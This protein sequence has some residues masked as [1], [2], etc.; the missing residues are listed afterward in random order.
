MFC[1]SGCD[2]LIKETTKETAL[3]A[4]E[5]ALSAETLGQAR[6]KLEDFYLS[7]QEASD[8]SMDEAL[9]LV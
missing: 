9:H 3:R 1:S 8:R 2:T 6:K 7:I 4:F 5:I